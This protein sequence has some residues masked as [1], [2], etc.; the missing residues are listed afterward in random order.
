M[1]TPYRQLGEGEA[2]PWREIDLRWQLTHIAKDPKAQQQR[3]KQQA[4]QNKQ[5]AR[6]KEKDAR[7]R[8]K[9]EESCN[10]RLEIVFQRL[11]KAIKKAAARGDTEFEC[12][13]SYYYSFFWSR[14]LTNYSK[15]PGFIATASQLVQ[16]LRLSGLGA[17]ST[18]SR[19]YL[20]WDDPA[21]WGAE[22][23]PNA[24]ID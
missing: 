3:D 10:E 12:E 13:V 18:R 9:S 11:V 4:R 20:C 24:G 5:R 14:V 2:V 15:T 19:L 22:F 1:T 21:H 16:R 23:I 17:Y 6:A 8:A 7:R